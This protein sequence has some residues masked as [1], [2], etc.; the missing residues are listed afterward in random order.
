MFDWIFKKKNKEVLNNTSTIPKT[1]KDLVA[2]LILDGLGVYPDTKGNAVLLAKTPFLDRAWTKGRSCLIHASGTYVGLPEGEPGNSE[3]GHLNL[4]AGRVVPQSLPRINDAILTKQLREIEVVKEAIATAQKNGGRIHLVGLMSD[5]GVH[6]HISHL[7]H[8]LDLCKE[9]NLSPIIHAILDGRD[10]GPIDAYFFISQLMSKL[11]KDNSGVLA[12][13]MG[14]LYAMD[15]DSR[16]ERT[17]Q[18]Y[19]AMIGLG[20]NKG[21]DP[22]AVLDE[23]YK[24]K[25]TDEFLTPTTI[26]DSNGLPVGDIK[27][28]DVVIF[29]NF[30]E[31]RARQL[32][33]SFII[34]DFYGFNK[35]FTPKDLYFAT[36]TGY[37]DDLPTHVIFPPRKILNTLSKVLSKEKKKQL[38]ISETEKFM[39]VTYFFNGGVE[40]ENEGEDFFNVPSPKV[41]DYS[42]APLMSAGTIT[43]EVL[44]R[45]KNYEKY[46][47]NFIVINY[48]NPDMLGHTGNIDATTYAN[49]FIDKC[50]KEVS[51]AVL[52]LGGAV[53][54]IADHG[55]CETMINRET[56]KVDNAHTNNPVPFILLDNPDMLLVK[57]KEEILRVGTGSNA[58][59]KGI[60][61]D[62][63]PTVLSILS[64]KKPNEMTGMDMLDV[65]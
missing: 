2:L 39:Q 58:Q 36:M 32:T 20:K 57:E 50:T 61:G 29:L 10:T 40:K 12:S 37:D 21:T 5:A 23:A 65:V 60:L 35:S 8:M 38:H 14:R 53:I 52:N 31:D 41:F 51:E 46:N 34:S 28:N 56:G 62:I 30:R 64:I 4:G 48:A 63:S 19:N 22:F 13:M 43:E 1:K 59:I 6:G 17:E 27:D 18:A 16:W 49:E 55:N 45:L 7:F 15:R 24:R 26:V 25:E 47:Y 33:K 9:Y 3:V 11:R 44:F 54:I 42:Q